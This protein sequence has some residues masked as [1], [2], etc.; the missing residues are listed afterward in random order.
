GPA[1]SAP[2]C[3]S[4][5][6][7]ARTRRTWAASSTSSNRTRNR[8][9]RPLPRGTSRGIVARDIRSATSAEGGGTVRHR[10]LFKLAAAAAFVLALAL[11]AAGSATSSRTAEDSSD[12]PD[13][14]TAFVP[15]IVHPS[16]LLAPDA[17]SS[18]AH[19]LS[20]FGARVYP[21]QG[22]GGYTSVHTDVHMVYDTLSNQLLPG[23]H[24]DLTMRS[25]QCLTDF[26]LDFD[27]TNSLTAGGTGP[28]LTVGSVEVNGQP[29][30]FAFKQPTYPGDPNGQ[31]D[32]DPAAH[33]ISNSNPVSATNPNPPACSPTVNGNAQNGLQ[34]PATKLVITP[35]APIAGGSTFTVTVDYT[36]RPGLHQDGD[37]S[38]EGWFPVNTAGAP[39][40]GSFVRTEPVGTFA[41]MPLNNYPTAKPTYDFYDTVPVGETAV[42]NGEIVGFSP[43]V[44]PVGGDVSVPP[45]SVN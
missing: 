32:P 4:A 16:A 38:T 28:N 41:W 35:S 43:P 24:V 44:A 11:P 9:E 29:A 1:G 34:C 45:T 36:G 25:T 20:P 21:E 30:S 31:D 6:C 23:N 22:N 17:C 39:N 10:G 3:S 27:A 33:A 40:D 19:S 12:A 7:A 42:A 13:G 8:L 5:R 37:G 26:S 14:A 2:R 18:G 15:S